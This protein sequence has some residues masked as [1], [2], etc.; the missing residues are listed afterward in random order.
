LKQFKNWYKKKQKRKNGKKREGEGENGVER[1]PA[2][3][4]EEAEYSGA[5]L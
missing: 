4:E 5:R 1:P 2:L 3:Q